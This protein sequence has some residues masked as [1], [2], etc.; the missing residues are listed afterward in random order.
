MAALHRGKRMNDENRLPTT[1]VEAARRQDVAMLILKRWAGCWI[2]LVALAVC[3][4]T[5]ALVIG[6]TK[7]Y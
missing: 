7:Q 5:P 4:F 6:W 2:D 1:V 3:L